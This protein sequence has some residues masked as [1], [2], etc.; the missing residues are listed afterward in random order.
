MAAGLTVDRARRMALAAQGF[1][2]GRPRGRV[3]VRHFRRVLGRVRLVQLD[4]VNVVA[5]AHYL[6]FFA[7]IGPYARSALD[8]WL[9]GSGEV[10]EYW[11]HE[12]SLIPVEHRPLFGHR[13]TGSHRHWVETFEREHPGYIEAVLEEVRSKGPIGV[14]GLDEPGERTGPWWGYGPGKRTLE[15]LFLKGRVTVARRVHFARRYEIPERVFPSHV[16]ERPMLGTEEAR[17]ELLRLAVQAHG[18]GT[19][20]DLADYYRLRVPE[21]RPL[22]AGLARA[23]EVEEVEVEGWRGPVY[24]DPAARVPRRVEGR[25]LLAPFDPLIWFRPRT[26]RLFGFRYRVE[27]Y[28]P[29]AQRRFGYYVLPFLL[30]GDLVARV[31]LKADRAGGRLHVRGAFAEE[32]ADRSR[33]ARELAAELTEMATWLELEGVVVQRRGDLAESLRRAL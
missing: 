31:D 24:L 28:V 2:D 15:W 30:D 19:L 11:A 23:G 12:A 21:A 4:S 5:R 10:F 9:W 22:L 14:G 32:G 33:V 1:C 7:R 27:I 17:R 8:A 6:P 20:A 3:D 26:E 13:M 25:A 18:V 29:A 16:L